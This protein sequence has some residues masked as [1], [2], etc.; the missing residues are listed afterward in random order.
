MP[1]ANMSSRLFFTLEGMSSI[2]FLYQYSFQYFMDILYSVIQKSEKLNQIPKTNHENRLR[3][4]TQELLDRTYSNAQKGLLQEHQTTLALRM[5]Q[6]RKNDDEKFGKFF[7]MLIRSSGSLESRLSPVL[8]DGRLTKSQLTAIEE[9]ESVQEFAGLVASMENEESRW[10]SF[11]DHPNA[12]SSVPEPWLQN[13]PDIS[14]EI[15]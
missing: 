5:V 12:E 2:H 1:L 7:S 11:L 14:K 8:L 15:N 10:L 3:V 4:L 6:I 9:I 13:N